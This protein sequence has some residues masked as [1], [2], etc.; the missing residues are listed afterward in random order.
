M[1]IKQLLRSRDDPGFPDLGSLSFGWNRIKDIVMLRALDHKDDQTLRQIRKSLYGYLKH[2]LDLL[3]ISIIRY[4]GGYMSHVKNNRKEQ[5]YDSGRIVM[6]HFLTDAE[7]AVATSSSKRDE[8]I[9]PLF[10][11]SPAT[12]APL[13]ERHRGRPSEHK[14][15]SDRRLFRE[16]LRAMNENA[17]VYITLHGMEGLSVSIEGWRQMP[18]Q[19]PTINFVVV[20]RETRDRLLREIEGLWTYLNGFYW[21][22]FNLRSFLEDNLGN[23]GLDFVRQRWGMESESRKRS[24]EAALGRARIGRN[25]TAPSNGGT[26]ER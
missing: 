13:I 22:K 3:I 18:L 9:L 2:H 23:P 7:K 26:K 15:L 24:S 21:F 4:S 11:R 14:F 5:A 20:I 25:A 10:I 1:E 8:I 6:L 17:T 19:Y 16:A 12:S